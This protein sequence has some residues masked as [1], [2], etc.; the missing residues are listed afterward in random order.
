VPP[1][2]VTG[3]VGKALVVELVRAICSQTAGTFVPPVYVLTVERTSV[4]VPV[5]RERRR[6]CDA[7]RS[8]DRIGAAL[9]LTVT[10]AG[11]TWYSA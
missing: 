1:E 3:P 2:I 6:T 4:P 7:A 5:F 9:L 10:D 11:F 8:R